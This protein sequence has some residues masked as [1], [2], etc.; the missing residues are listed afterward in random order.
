MYRKLLLLFFP[1]IVWF[2][3][4][5][6]PSSRL[7]GQAIDA[8]TGEPIAGVHVVGYDYNLRDNYSVAFE[9]MTGEDGR[10]VAQTVKPILILYSK[11]GY[12]P[13]L[14]DVRHEEI[15]KDKLF[16]GELRRSRIEER[17]KPGYIAG[18]VQE[19]ASNEKRLASEVRVVL[20]EGEKNTE[21]AGITDS[22]GFFIIDRIPEG[23]YLLKLSKKGYLTKKVDSIRVAADSVT[24]QKLDIHS[25]DEPVKLCGQVRDSKEYNPL[26][27]VKVE[28]VNENGLVVSSDT[29]DNN[30]FYFIDNVPRGNPLIRFSRKGYNVN[31]KSMQ[32]LRVDDTLVNAELTPKPFWLFRL[33]SKKYASVAGQVLDDETG[34]PLMV[35][36]VTV[37]TNLTK[38][39]TY[40]DGKGKFRIFNIPPG[41][42][43]LVFDRI[44]YE[45]YELSVKL[46]PGGEYYFQVRL[47]MTKAIR[48]EY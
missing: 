36:K 11:I 41:E 20:C 17:S 30:G 3:C 24:F 47:T 48:V 28:L 25:L 32:L 12:E 19:E 45:L 21:Y 15:K 1:L 40:T 35:A 23:S 16:V 26:N 2:L 13:S 46:E 31:N 14:I 7:S 38:G 4:G 33:F 9:T 37:L 10:Y 29:T 43:E 22:L 6:R 34:V 8:E 44:A 39:G 5:S 27:K 18:S 42:C